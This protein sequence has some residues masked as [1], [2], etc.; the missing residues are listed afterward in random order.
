[1]RP[2][3]IREKNMSSFD[4]H[5]MNGMSATERPVT[6]REKDNIM[7]ELYEYRRN[8][9]TSFGWLRNTE[10]RCDIICQELAAAGYIE[11][12]NVE[13]LGTSHTTVHITPTGE[14]FCETKSF[15]DSNQPLARK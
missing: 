13:P 5:R 2:T 12:I 4:E 14:R 9:S 8:K 7:R 3:R 1:M 6:S 10:E 15:S 11:Y